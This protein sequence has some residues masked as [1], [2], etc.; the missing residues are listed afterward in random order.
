MYAAAGSKQNPP[1]RSAGSRFWL[2]AGN[3]WVMKVNPAK[4]PDERREKRRRSTVCFVI[5]AA[6]ITAGAA[7]CSTADRTAMRFLDTAEHHTYTGI[8]LIEQEK[9]GDAEREFERAVQLNDKS[10]LGYAGLALIGAIRG[11]ADQAL[12]LIEQAEQYARDDRERLFIQVAR[13]RL[14]TLSRRPANWVELAQ[15]EFESSIDIDPRS[16]PAYYFM[17][18]A[19]MRNH[20]FEKAARHFIKVLDLNDSY[21]EQADRQWKRIMTIS[22]AE[23]ASFRV[24]EAALADTLTRGRLALL[25]VEELRVDELCRGLGLYGGSPVPEKPPPDSEMHPCRREIEKIAALGLQGLELYPDGN[26]YP[27]GVVSRLNLAVVLY[28]ILVKVTGDERLADRYATP[29]S[30]TGEEGKEQFLHEAARVIIARDIMDRELFTSSELAPYEP[31]S[32]DR[33]LMAIHNFREA[34]LIGF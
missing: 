8:V 31:I 25:L 4:V 9:Y 10:A 32:G 15:K 27:D 24:E 14:Y 18:L 6:A 11:Q 30:E 22:A 34:L 7:S 5:L 1:D 13:I 2:G 20:E 21:I 19:R 23:P 12:S 16:A 3:G 33:A 29:P 26:F 28:N 17:G